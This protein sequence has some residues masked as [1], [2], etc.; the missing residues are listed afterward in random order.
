MITRIELSRKR[1]GSSYD[2]KTKKYVTYK[3]AVRVN[4]RRY[5]QSGFPNRKAA[6][7]FVEALKLKKAYNRLGLSFTTNVRLSQLLD[8]RLS[9][10]NK[11]ERVRATRIFRDFQTMHGDP[12]V[13]EI[14]SSHLQRY[15]NSRSSVKPETVI[16]EVAMLTAAFRRA[17]KMFPDELED[18]QP[19]TVARPKLKRSKINRRIV[20]EAEKDA[21]VAYLMQG[22]DYS[23]MIAR[24][25]EL[26]WYFGLRYGEVVKLLK[27]DYTGD[28]LRVT[29]W[30]TND[31]TVFEYLPERVKEILEA[32][33]AES[34]TKHIFPHGR[35]IYPNKFY[36]TLK[37]AVESAG[38]KYGRRPDS[39]SFHS[40]RH[41]FITRMV[42]V[43]DLPTVQAYSAHSDAAMVALY[44]HTS[45]TKKRAAFE[46][47]YGNRD[48][49]AV[50]D[51]IR[52][53]EMS[54]EEFEAVIKS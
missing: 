18:Y 16:R 26:A 31:E 34:D 28:R 36:D 42:E 6:E 53:G 3:I 39:V 48:W 25:W 49:R 30:K 46:R 43:A 14:R 8:K 20:S 50:Y 22:D 9:M 45:E 35:F 2:P 12:L 10:L 52:R 13:T 54:F 27:S 33:I 19:P 21:V 38:M 1:P 51:Q 11:P 32:A 47:L 17:P 29:R 40:L 15:I 5:R 23:R 7:A 37:P 41:S 44:S 24:Q 4:G